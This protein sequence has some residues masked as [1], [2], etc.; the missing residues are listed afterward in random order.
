[1]REV[2]AASSLAKP[3]EAIDRSQGAG[4]ARRGRR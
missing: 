1:V 3:R 4:F 2:A